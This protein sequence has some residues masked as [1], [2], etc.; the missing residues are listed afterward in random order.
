MNEKN[1]MTG[2][3]KPQKLDGFVEDL[4]K[5]VPEI[6]D[7]VVE[8]AAAPAPGLDQTKKDGE[9]PALYA[10]L[11]DKYGRAFDPSIHV[12]DNEGKPIVNRAARLRGMLKIRSGV[13]KPTKTKS[14]VARRRRDPAPGPAPV[15]EEPAIAEG[16]EEKPQAESLPA[17]VAGALAAGLTFQMGQ[18]VFGDEGA[19]MR[20]DQLDEEKFMS[21]AYERYFESTGAGSNVSPGYL[22]L[23]AVGYYVMRRLTMPKPRK[24]ISA[25]LSKIGQAGAWAWD[26]VR[27][28]RIKKSK[29]KNGHGSHID[30]RNDGE[31]EEH[32][33]KITMPNAQAAE[34][35]GFGLRSVE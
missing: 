5:A 9:A 34:L 30:S 15:S 25:G 13:R 31:R 20:D 12:T 16:I 10:D 8:A 4:E 14:K 32:P 11:K 6:S 3:N 17:P 21:N 26:K 2:G 22:I 28:I 33:S 24:R 23:I 18:I 7:H 1:G 19:P 35:G 27:G 29:E